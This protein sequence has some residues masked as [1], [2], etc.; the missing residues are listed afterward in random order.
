MTAVFVHTIK[1]T[2]MFSSIKKKSDMVWQQILQRTFLIK[3]RYS[4][5]FTETIT[6]NI[7]GPFR[8]HSIKRKL[9]KSLNHLKPVNCDQLNWPVT[10]KTLKSGTALTAAKD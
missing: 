5:L 10:S 2:M 8:G 4:I 7:T 9:S 6:Q 3:H 1:A